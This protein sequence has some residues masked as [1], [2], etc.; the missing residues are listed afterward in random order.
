MSAPPFIDS[1][2][3]AKNG[4]QISG[5]MLI[6][7]LLRLSDVL[8]NSQGVLRYTVQ[9]GLNKYGVPMLVLS[10]SG[11]CTLRCQRCLA[12]LDYP[13]ALNT[14][15]LLR[16][17]AELDALDESDEAECDSIL[18]QARL[19]VQDLFEDEVLLN[20]PFAPKH[21]AGACQA[22]N[23]D[24]AAL[25]VKHPFAALAKLKT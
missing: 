25:D 16:T 3:F 13:V 22:T 21:E 19:D 5:E 18:A 7:D 24:G 10:L 1:L 20:L 9:G 23:R 11:C 14:T 15:V 12:A 17:Q 6:A 8:E 2:D 4:Q